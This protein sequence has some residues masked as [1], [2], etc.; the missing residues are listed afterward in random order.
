MLKE[1]TDSQSG[2]LKHHQPF[3]RDSLHSIP[4]AKSHIILNA[5]VVKQSQSGI[6]EKGTAALQRSGHLW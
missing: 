3:D 2:I 4:E 1:M 6:P 5:Q